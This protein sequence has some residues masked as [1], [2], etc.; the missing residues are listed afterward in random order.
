MNFLLA[1][2]THTDF[3]LK[4]DCDR[5]RIW[6]HEDDLLASEFHRRFLRPILPH[7]LEWVRLVVAGPEVALLDHKPRGSADHIRG[8]D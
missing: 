5:R 3:C 4:S 1:V 2:T 8:A 6:V 7:D